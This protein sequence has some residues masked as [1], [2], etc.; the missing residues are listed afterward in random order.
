MGG[1]GSP[2]GEPPP[3][4]RC[5]GGVGFPREVVGGLVRLRIEYVS[6]DGGFLVD[7]VGLVTAGLARSGCCGLLG[8][9]V[10]AVGAL[11]G[12]LERAQ[13][14]REVRAGELAQRLGGVILVGAPAR[15]MDRWL[16]GTTSR[17][18]YCSA[19]ITTSARP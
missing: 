17:E 5:S 16:C 13:R 1:G 8:G 11:D 10:L 4:N 18:A 15:R 7:R 12:A 9:G 6:F 2:A 14:R 19:A 3:R